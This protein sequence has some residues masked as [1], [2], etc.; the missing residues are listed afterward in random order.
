[1]EFLTKHTTANNP[2]LKIVAMTLFIVFPFIGFVLGAQYQS[3]LDKTQ[4]R[5]SEYQKIV[6]IP[7]PTK[8]VDV[9]TN[10]KT[11]NSAKNN[12]SFRIPNEFVVSENSDGVKIFLNQGAYEKS[13]SCKS[14]G[15]ENP[16]SPEL[17]SIMYAETTRSKNPD[18]E[19]YINEKLGG[20]SPPYTIIHSGDLSWTMSAAGGLQ[21]RPTIRAFAYDKDIIRFIQTDTYIMPLWNYIHNSN[22]QFLASDVESLIKQTDWHDIESLSSKVVSTFHFSK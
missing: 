13:K 12:F 21:L 3:L 10:W 9:L 17:I 8:A 14:T 5:N 7:I 6:Q 16:C 4:N 11:Y 18:A 2:V 15:E 1:M 22:K 19:K 20:I